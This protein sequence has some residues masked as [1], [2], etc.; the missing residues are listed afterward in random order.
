MPAGAAT[1]S[2]RS[3]LR[4]AVPL[5]GHRRPGPQLRRARRPAALR[6]PAPARRRALDRQHGCSIDW[7]RRR[8]SPTSCAPRSRRSTATASTAPKLVALVR[9]VRAGLRATSPPHPGSTLGQGHRT[10]C[11]LTRPPRKLVDDGAAG[12]VPAQ[13]VLRGAAQEARRRDRLHHG[14]HRRRR[15]GGRRWPRTRIAG[16]GASSW[17]GARP[18]PRP[19]GRCVRPARRRRRHRRRRRR[20]RRAARAGRRAAATPPPR[21]AA[22]CTPRVVDLLD[23]QATRDWAAAVLR[24]SSAGSTAWSTSSAAGAAASP[25]PRPTWPTGTLLQDLLIR[26]LQHTSLAFHDS[27]QRSDDGAAT[28]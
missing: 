22:T 5:P 27:L 9:R 24:R 23:E 13:H 19:A 2:T 8:R 25:S 10:R 21:A 14:D 11:D 28:C 18:A 3:L 12:R 16:T 20:Q 1:C 7:E 17:R 15:T 4:P 6:L 26:T